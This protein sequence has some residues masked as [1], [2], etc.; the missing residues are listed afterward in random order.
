MPQL[1]RISSDTQV[2]DTVQ[3]LLDYD[4]IHYP[5]MTSKN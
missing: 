3:S 1:L 2:I 5:E 4:L